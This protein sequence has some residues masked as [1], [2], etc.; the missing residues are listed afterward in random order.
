MKISIDDLDLIT[1]VA[2]LHLNLE[3]FD[4]FDPL[5]IPD[6]L[7][8]VIKKLRIGISPPCYGGP[9]WAAEIYIPNSEENLSHK[10][11]YCRE[12]PTI[13]EAVMKTA[14]AY[15]KHVQRHEQKS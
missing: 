10:T 9:Y 1:R 2:D 8:E 7:I 6:H 13:E 12:A 15:A 11:N 4:S 14:L 3:G 5:N